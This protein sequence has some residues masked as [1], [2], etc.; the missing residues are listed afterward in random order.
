[1]HSNHDHL[2]AA[3][4]NMSSD[5][6]VF[7][8]EQVK[9]LGHIVVDGIVYAAACHCALRRPC[10]FSRA[11][12]YDISRFAAFHPGGESVL[13]SAKGTDAS[14]LFHLYH[15]P[16]VLIKYGDKLRVGALQGY[17]A[18]QAKLPGAFGDCIPYADPMW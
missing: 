9:A 5:L 6:P 12:R 18:P 11:C 4:K 1:M 7:T 17:S 8:L 15:N 10:R 3:E 2:R 14:S 13:V 16:S